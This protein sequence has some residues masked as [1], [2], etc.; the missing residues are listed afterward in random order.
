MNLSDN[1]KKIRKDNNL[2]QEQLAD[3]LGVSRQSV[4]KWE[5]G[6]AYPEMDKVLQ[7]CKMFNLNI[8]ELL[9]QNIK[10]VNDNKQTKINI[11]KYI[12]DFLDYVTKTIDMFSSMRFKEKVKCIFEQCIIAGI[13]S[14]ALLIV[15]AI[16]LSIFQD[17]FRFLP[18]NIYFVLYQ[19]FSDIYAI[20]CL[21]LGI[22]LLLHIFKVRYLDYYVIVKDNNESKDENVENEGKEK[23]ET[24]EEL[25]NKNKTV[26]LK[27]KPEK[28]IIRDPQ[29]SGYKFISGL[30]RCLLFMIKCIVAFIA[31]GYCFSLVGFVI[32]LTVS[33]IFIKTGLLFVGV[34]ICLVSAIII[35]LLVLNVLY[36][37]IISKKNRE[38]EQG[39]IFVVALI[40]CGVGFGISTIGLTQFEV[41]TNV[42]NDYYIQDEKTISM[43]D[44]LVIAP[45]YHVDYMESDSND[46]KIVY[47]HSKYYDVDITYED[48]FIYFHLVSN[49]DDL[50]EMSRVYINDI[51]NR[52]IVDYSN[53]EIKVYTSKE[54]ID[55]IFANLN[56]YYW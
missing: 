19:I 52:K 40:L 43:T 22:V 14:L 28:I 2:S 1:L 44:D 24:K 39:I 34:L 55:K 15:G 37:F 51:N 13:I 46:I 48:N 21:V 17:I 56:N 16:G 32:C 26:F 30:L 12:D 45:Y 11:N 27:K 41:I 4:S 36:N 35:N 20:G 9:N 42:D 25:D 50:M 18:D 47:T 33:F 7:I 29:H 31:I 10:E 5:S 23:T 8:D 38:K 49:Y 53:A 6:Q 3:K 54:N